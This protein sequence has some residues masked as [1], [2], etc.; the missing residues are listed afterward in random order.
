MV[1][2]VALVYSRL[3]YQPS[4]TL[5]KSGKMN[6][7]HEGLKQLIVALKILMAEGNVGLTG[8]LDKVVYA[9]ERKLRITK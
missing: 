5:T 2:I 3:I 8:P 6:T 1:S 7:C 9:L 4:R